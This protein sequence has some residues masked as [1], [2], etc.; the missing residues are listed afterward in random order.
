MRGKASLITSLANQK[1]VDITD[2]FTFPKYIQK[3]DPR[4]GCHTTQRS[5]YSH[6]S[7]SGLGFVENEISSDY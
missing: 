4:E 2:G 1:N 7:M 5:K 6:T 3:N